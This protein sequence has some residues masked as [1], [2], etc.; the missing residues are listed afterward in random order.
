MNTSFI[1]SRVLLGTALCLALAVPALA[2]GTTAKNSP[3][4]KSSTAPAK[5]SGNKTASTE[6]PDKLQQNLDSFAHKTIGSINRCV[7][8]SSGKKEVKK[9]PDGSFTARYIEVDPKS[10]AT[11]YKPSENNNKLVPYIGY[12]RYDEVEY[13]STAATQKEALDGPFKQS[14]RVS[15]TELVKYVKGKWSY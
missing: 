13:V 1:I 9:N 4:Q 6:A 2:E 3:A 11:S 12:M 15:M 10:V 14:S 8:P 7:L 5:S